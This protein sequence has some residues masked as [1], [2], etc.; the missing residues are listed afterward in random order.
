[1]C[2]RKNVLLWQ[3]K[4]LWQR[5]ELWLIT[6]IIET[7]E[8]VTNCLHASDWASL[9]LFKLFKNEFH[10]FSITGSDR[11]PDLKLN[12]CRCFVSVKWSSYEYVHVS[13]C[14]AGKW[15]R[16]YKWIISKDVYGVTTIYDVISAETLRAF[17]VGEYT[18]RIYSNTY[19]LIKHMQYTLFIYKIGNMNVTKLLTINSSCGNSIW[20]MQVVSLVYL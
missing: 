3:T 9:N 15:C 12:N 13:K 5:S 20:C 19:R 8:H 1:M 10:F 7:E 2:D 16:I 4:F 18:R 14:T 11:S 17:V 6:I